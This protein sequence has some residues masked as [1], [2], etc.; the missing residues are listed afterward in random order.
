L[1]E[2]VADKIFEPEQLKVFNELPGDQ[3]NTTIQETF[4]PAA[5]VTLPEDKADW[6]EMTS[7]WTSALLAKT[8]AAWPTSDPPPNLQAEF[9]A[10]RNG[11]SLRAFDFAAQ[12]NV[13]LQMF[14]LAATNA[15]A[16]STVEFTP[17]DQA[18]WDEFVGSAKTDFPEQ[19]RSM[20]II[21]VSSDG[22]NRYREMRDA[23]TENNVVLV[24]IAPRGIGPTIWDQSERKQIQNRR[25][26]YLLGQT[27]DG[28]RVLDVRRGIQAIRQVPAFESIPIRITAQRQMA[29]IAL[30]A[31]LFEKDVS[32]MNLCELPAT[33]RDGPFLLNVRRV[34]DMPQAVA[35]AADR[36]P[37]TIRSVDRADFQYSID[38]LDRIGRSDQLTIAK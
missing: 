17:L 8:F 25:R 33:H 13:A 15:K 21:N 19:F 29:G 24:F 9:A 1:I 23:I 35:M 31:G 36:I 26:F 10:E 4:V 7:T 22:K 16:P 2:I 3:L 18:G 34:L 27:L 11:I 38:A 20:P 30:Y 6:R 32:G 28:M 12:D 14:V 37:L 5:S